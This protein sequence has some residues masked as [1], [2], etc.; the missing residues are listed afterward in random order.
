MSSV[1]AKINFLRIFTPHFYPAQVIFIS[2]LKIKNV[3]DFRTSDFS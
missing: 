1:P 2:V 3:F